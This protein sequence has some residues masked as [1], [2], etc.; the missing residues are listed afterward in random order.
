MSI[1]MLFRSA[2]GFAFHVKGLSYAAPLLK[3]VLRVHIT[4]K[5]GSIECLPLARLG[6]VYRQSRNTPCLMLLDLPLDLF[7][8]N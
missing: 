5:A 2:R 3:L 8:V 4:D 6:L 7:Y 1:P